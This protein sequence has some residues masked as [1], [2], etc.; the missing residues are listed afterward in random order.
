MGENLTWW[1]GKD[2]DKLCSTCGGQISDDADKHLAVDCVEVLLAQRKELAGALGTVVP[3]IPLDEP[4]PHHDLIV[5]MSTIYGLLGKHGSFTVGDLIK[6]HELLERM[7]NV[8][9]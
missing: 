5:S 1:D 2:E 8:T 7:K 4:E 6:A 9:N 3:D